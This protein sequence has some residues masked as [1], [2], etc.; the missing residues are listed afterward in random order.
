MTRSPSRRG[1]RSSTPFADAL[2][3]EFLLPSKSQHTSSALRLESAKNQK[4]KKPKGHETRTNVSIA[5]SELFGQRRHRRAIHWNYS[6]PRV[7]KYCTGL[8]RGWSNGERRF[9][10]E[11]GVGPDINH[12]YVKSS[13]RTSTDGRAYVYVHIRTYAY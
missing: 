1:V 12:F 7:T 13:K 3:I 2:F 8:G 6:V 11:P 5:V 9:R 4:P 10:G